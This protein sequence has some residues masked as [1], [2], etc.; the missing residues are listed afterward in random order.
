MA[1]SFLGVTRIINP[2][3]P[4]RG[5]EKLSLVRLPIYNYSLSIRRF[6]A[7]FVA[8]FMRVF[9]GSFAILFPHAG[10]F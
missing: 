1:F 4:V 9:S 8:W 10:Q 6:V 5:G 2:G 3:H 7:W